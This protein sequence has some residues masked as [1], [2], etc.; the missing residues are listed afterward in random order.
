MAEGYKSIADLLIKVDSDVSGVRSGLQEAQGIVANFSTTGAGALGLFDAGLGK[1]S[2]SVLALRSTMGIWITAAETMLSLFGKISEKGDGLAELAGRQDEWGALKAAVDDVKEAIGEGLT[3]AFGRAQVAAKDYLGVQSALAAGE[4]Q[5]VKQ[6][7]NDWNKV[8]ERTVAMLGEVAFGFRRL[9]DP[10]TWSL[11]VVELEIER[12]ET[13]IENL[14]KQV[15]SFTDNPDQLA[16]RRIFGFDDIASTLAEIDLL[17]VKL[18]EMKDKRDQMLPSDPFKTVQNEEFPAVLALQKEIESLEIKAA[19]LGMT[20]AAAA[21]YNAE[22]RALNQLERDGGTD[23]EAFT[24]A[25]REKTSQIYALTERINAWNEAE[26]ERKKLEDDEVRRGQQIERDFARNE[27]NA[28]KM[29]LSAEKEGR[30]LA[31]KAATLGPVTQATAAQAAEERLLSAALSRNV[32]LTDLQRERIHE[33]AQEIGRQTVVLDQAQKAYAVYGDIGN[34]VSR[35]LGTA[36]SGY[37]KGSIKDGEDWM[38]MVQSMLQHLRDLLIQKLILNQIGNAITGGITNA[39][40]PSAAGTVAGA[41][42]DGG[43]VDGGSLYLVGERGPELFRPSSPGTIIP[44]G[45]TASGS[46]SPNVVL[47]I[48]APA[49]TTARETGRSANSDGGMTLDVL[50]EQIEGAMAQRVGEDRSTLGEAMKSRFGLSSAA[51]A[52]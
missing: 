5:D 22:Q 8:L 21:V 28:E 16:F 15:Q 47:N 17:N 12:I 1:V 7:T 23:V 45:A 34:T 46:A 38:K 48:S 33:A 52:R 36:W 26:R 31:I 29:V 35:D 44:N 18:Q 13:K 41:R 2:A 32:E 11:K 9:A 4:G 10:N 40:S 6:Q 51:G 20:A 43:P 30:A 19:T 3:G 24:R 25:M 39:F 14:S 42:A 49:G 50:I 27:E 37:I